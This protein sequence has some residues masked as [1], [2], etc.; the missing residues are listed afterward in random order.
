[1][2]PAVEKGRRAA[3]RVLASSDPAG[4]K[5][6]PTEK[7]KR[8][9]Q[10]CSLVE[11]EISYKRRLIQGRLD[12]LR[13]ARNAVTEK[14][15]ADASA[16]VKALPAILADQPSASKGLRHLR[17]PAPSSPGRREDDRLLE[18]TADPTQMS[19]SELDSEI[20]RL[21]ESETEAS[22]QRRRLLDLIDAIDAELVVRYKDEPA[23]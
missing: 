9:R 8:R 3:E 17:L 18:S 23:T 10:E 20:R 4:L 2:E 6:L 21:A 11:E 19:S 14:G 16:M 15:A 5:G 13:H 22:G 12:I 1:M 7:L